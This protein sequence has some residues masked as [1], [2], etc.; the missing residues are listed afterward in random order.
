[1]PFV[2]ILL[3]GALLV[4]GLAWAQPES[5]FDIS[6]K[7][8]DVARHILDFLFTGTSDIFNNEAAGKFY[9]VLRQLFMYYSGALLVF[10]VIVVLYHLIVMVAESAHYGIPLGKRNKQM[11]APIRLVTA[12]GLLIP[13]GGFSTAQFLIMQMTRMGSSLA[14]NAW[15]SFADTIKPTQ[16]TLHGSARIDPTATIAHL[17]AIGACVKSYEITYSGLATE[18]LVPF[19]VPPFLISKEES[20]DTFSRTTFLAKMGDPALLPV[21]CGN[22]SWVMPEPEITAS[23][24]SRVSARFAKA[25]LTAIKDIQ[26]GALNLG[27]SL[28][29]G[30]LGIFNTTEATYALTFAKLIE[31]YQKSFLGA[32][33]Q[34]KITIDKYGNVA[35]ISDERT[36]TTDGYG[37]MMAGVTLQKFALTDTVMLTPEL[38]APVVTFHYPL[39]AAANDKPTLLLARTLSFAH[40]L[41]QSHNSAAPIKE[42]W[43]NPTLDHGKGP[44]KQAL[45]LTANIVSRAEANLGGQSLLDPGLAESGANIGLFKP[46][47]LAFR[48]LDLA[49]QFWAVAD[50]SPRANSPVFGSA[51]IFGNLAQAVRAALLTAN[52]RIEAAALGQ[53]SLL[54][55]DQPADSAR[56]LVAAIGLLIFI[57]ALLLVFLLPLIPLLHF[58]LGSVLWLIAVFQGI[59]SAPIW[60]LTFLSLKGDELVPPGSRLG[61][62]II[63]NIFLR[64]ILM[65]IGFITALMLMHMGFAILEVSLALF[66]YDGLQGSKTLFSLGTLILLIIYLLAAFAI[67]NVAMKCI[68]LFPDFTLKWLGGSGAGGADEGQAAGA[69]AS[70]GGGGGTGTAQAAVGGGGSGTG[71]NNAQQVWQRK[72]LGVLEQLSDHF[73][74]GVK[75]TVQNSGLFAHIADRPDAPAPNA[76]GTGGNAPLAASGGTPTNVNVTSNVGGLSSSTSVVHSEGSPTRN[77]S[78]RTDG[79]I[80]EK[81]SLMAQT[82]RGNQT[83]K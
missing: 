61:L 12:L 14:S 79:A 28:A 72:L 63:L 36:T 42:L 3:L 6:G 40:L 27:G 17:A 70:A 8:Q 35:A 38:A 23:T 21:S 15:N 64:P 11:W 1:M 53:Q 39:F 29:L 77:S 76:T 26:Q 46:I 34:D 68:S 75:S 32:L 44:V 73:G 30:T 80:E 2:F 48:A 4:P 62:A 37:W 57:P 13:I 33:Q 67:T 10:A 83:D 5:L 16:V 41:L 81:N 24:M 82:I 65:V 22:L 45:T 50:W 71:G 18:R 20:G 49:D 52:P 74:G 56:Y 59:A 19:V 9:G 66:Q 47:A 25:H 51:I 78:G 69:G 31:T 7:P 54:D 60:A 58:A 43:F 55:I